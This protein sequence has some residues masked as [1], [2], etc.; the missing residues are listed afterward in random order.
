MDES[1]SFKLKAIAAIGSIGTAQLIAWGS[2][3]YA[4]AVMGA[5]MRRELGLSEPQ[6]FAAF[7]SSLA[8]SGQLAPWAGKLVDRHGGRIVLSAGMSLGAL[9]FAT[10]AGVNA[11][12]LCILA[13]GLQGVAM[14]LALYDTCFAALA[15][16]YAG[17]YRRAVTFV[18]L[19]A[20]LASSVF[21][22]STHHLISRLGWRS[23]CWVLAFLLIAAAG[24]N[25][26]AFSAR[27]RDVHHRP[28][29]DGT[30][31]P[32]SVPTRA[33]WLIV[34]FAA[35]SFVN[36][37]LSAHL[38]ATLRALHFADELAVWIAA[39]V[40]VMQVL[41]RALEFTMSA[42]VSA[43]RLGLVTIAGLFASLFILLASEGVPALALTFA[44]VYG[45]ANGVMTVVRAVLPWQ[46]FGSQQLGA[47]LGRFAAP[48]LAARALAPFAF[49]AFASPFG[50]RG[51]LVCTV[52]VAGVS[53]AT[54][55]VAVPVSAAQQFDVS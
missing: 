34:A 19:I 4:I 5:S 11:A 29:V 1:S 43:K 38:P 13:L 54:Y 32:S 26:L 10:L 22:P 33:R 31:E 14:A 51:A 17:N 6:L 47:V 18:T 2:L 30:H 48:S 3:Y 21:W 28:Q 23:T 35:A 7:A 36:A 16:Q 20:G 53:L 41:G 39:S 52:L 55:V 49:S 12:W 40:G 42:R 44:I 45:A 15:Q 46:L 27:P 8:L 50:T 37:A 9:G 25:A 24:M